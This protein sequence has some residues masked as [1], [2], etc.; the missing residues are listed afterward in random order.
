MSGKSIKERSDEKMREL[1]GPSLGA[2]PPPELAARLILAYISEKDR[3]SDA[4]Y[5]NASQVDKSSSEGKLIVFT[6][7]TGFL[8][9]TGRPLL[10]AKALRDLGAAV[11]FMAGA[12]SSGEDE[13][14]RYAY[15]IKQEGFKIY[16][17][18]SQAGVRWIMNKIQVEATWG[19]YD[20]TMIREEVQ[21][22]RRALQGIINDWNTKPH[23]IV[24]DLS[25]VMSITTE[26]EEIPFISI[27]NF[28]WTNHARLKLSPPE[29]HIITRISL[30]LGI[31][32][33]LEYLETTN[34]IFSML[35]L[36]W[37]KPYNKV[38]KGLGLKRKYN[39]YDQMSG[40]LI[41]MPDFAAFKGME[42]TAAALPIGPLTWEPKEE[43]ILAHVDM[44]TAESFRT[45]LDSAPERPL[46]YLTMG[47]TGALDLFLMVIAA[48][49]DR[50]YRLAITTG[51]QFEI[52]RLG[53]LPS[54]VFAIP[55]YPGN[56]ILQKASVT[57]NHGGSGSAYQAM[58]A[59]VPQI[60]IP[61]HADQQ[62]NADIV[63]SEGADIRLLR[64]S[65]TEAQI[66]DAVKTLLEKTM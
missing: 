8:A 65:L 43:D 34:K 22:H 62:W 33:V 26:M 2:L 31:S 11:V 54:N 46:V 36:S 5:R 1:Y 14:G 51:G 4:W 24:S 63:Q 64:R 38:R 20:E 32:K 7:H 52:A 30:A 49:K 48:L 21:S 6:C 41:L 59:G 18:P 50:P 56:R 19:W 44:T 15:L 58:T 66:A 12:E 39:F 16:D 35:L 28:T 55:F 53:E 9:H 13:Q 45:F 10:V 57:I 61:T 37:V 3:K 60:M 42:I 23:A 29:A 25:Q 40:D 27:L 17:A 47:S